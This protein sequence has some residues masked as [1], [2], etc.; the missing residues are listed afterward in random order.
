MAID[1][2]Q[3]PDYIR[4]EIAPP[5]G[6]VER[7]EK[8]VWA[9]R[10]QEWLNYHDCR[11]S[12]DSDYGPATTECVK[13]FQTKI[14]LP[15]TGAVDVATWEALVKPMQMVLQSPENINSMSISEA[16]R[17]MAQQH[18]EQHPIEIGKANCGP[19]VRLYCSGNEGLQWAWCAGFVSLIMHQAYFYKNKPSPIEGSVSC[20]SLAAQG[21]EAGLFVIES[22]VTSERVSWDSLGGCAIFLRRRTSTDWT[23]TG[24]ALSA[25]GV[26]NALVFNTIEGNTNDEGSREG[27]EAC[28]RKRSMAGENY[29]FMKFV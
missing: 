6:T 5:S 17:V 28:R 27:Y 9:K 13:D 20:D 18:V 16:V 21:R 8:S 14:G 23:H 19:W 3:A 26:G 11:T 24:F 29:D 15:S 10:I 1:F 4:S 12:I 2:D 22:D 7:G 25:T